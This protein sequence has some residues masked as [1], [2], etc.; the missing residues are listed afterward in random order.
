MDH[1]VEKKA[2]LRADI[3]SRMK[4]MDEAKRTYSDTALFEQFLS[5][6]CLEKVQTILLYYGVGAEPNTRLLIDELLTENKEVFLPRCLPDYQMEARLV[7]KNSKWKYNMYGIPET[8]DNEPIINKRDIDLIVCPA[9]ACDVQGRRLGQ[10]GGY[11]DRYLQDYQG[12][13]L[14]FCRDA[15]LQDHVPTQEHD[16]P[17]SLVITETRI[18]VR[19]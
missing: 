15:Y 17:M 12:V 14:A 3:R 16:I 9:L 11:Y 2:R 19:D 5:M 10:A 8:C 6:S 7:R 18:L 4:Q 13:T 1:I